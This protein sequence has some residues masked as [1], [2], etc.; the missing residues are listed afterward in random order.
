M[1]VLLINPSSYEVYGGLPPSF[2]I[3]L[4]LAYIASVAERA[5]Y[6]VN[7]IDIDVENL[8]KSKFIKRITEINPAIVGIT[9]TTPTYF[10]KR[11]Q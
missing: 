5:G 4:G 10:D 2:Q 11:L 6:D 3:P 9:C 1:K 8:T 7:V